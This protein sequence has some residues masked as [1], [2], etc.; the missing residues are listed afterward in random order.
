MAGQLVELADGVFVW[1]HDVRDRFTCNVGVVVNDA[2]ITLI[3]TSGVPSSYQ[4]LT[5]ALRRFDKS[6]E[7]VVLTHAHGDHI[8]GAASFSDAEIVCSSACAQSLASPPL[9]GP[10]QTLHPLVAEELRSL[11]HPTPTRIMVGSQPLDDRLTVDILSGHTQGDLVVRVDDA[12]TVFAGDLCF[13]GHVPLGIGA[14]FAEWHRSVEQLKQ[15]DARH[16]VPGH[17]SLGA[18]AELDVVAM[19]LEAVIEA[20]ANDAP[21]RSGPWSTWWDPWAERIPG[22]IDRINVEQARTPNAFPPTL[23]RLLSV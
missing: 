10:F 8:A 19:Y 7:R 12:D 14:D 18:R 5:V 13:F 6:V 20:A 22:A 16:V 23:L 4:A 9:I 15:L 1:L 21:M 17:G 3:D 2:G 11:S